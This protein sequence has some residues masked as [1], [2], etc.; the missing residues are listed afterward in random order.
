MMDLKVI[1]AT[2]KRYDIPKKN[3]LYP[4][5]A[6]AALSKEDLPYQRDDEGENISAKNK[7]YC[8]LTALYWAYKHIKADYIGLCHYR[9]YFDLSGM[10]EFDVILPKKRHYYIET[11]Y[12]QFKH[13]HG[14]EGLDKAREVI[15]SHYP[16][17]LPFFDEQMKNRSLHIYNMF[18]MRK[19]LFD[20]YCS[21]LFGVL[22][23]V[24]EE[25]GEISRLYGFIGER[26]LD[27]YV[28]R[29]NILYLETGIINTE[30]VNWPKKII[31][32]LE[33]KYFGKK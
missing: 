15:K 14:S 13:A 16:D 2:H 17:Y 20:N 27:V 26:L 23:K 7:T 4:V 12:D 9:R 5:F 28:Q 10:T 29:N 24:E 6:G 8:E 19:D 21:F 31:G 3:Y 32:F 25:L 1:V 33:R 11:V 22:E 30:T 18:I